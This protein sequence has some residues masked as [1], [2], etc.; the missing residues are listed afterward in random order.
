[1]LTDTGS[2]YRSHTC[3]ELG[4]TPKRTRTHRPRTNGRIERFHL[5]MADGW[6]FAGMFLTG[7]ARRKARP[8]WLHEY[9]HYRPHTAIGT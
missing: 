9:N 7:S 3:A 4:V 5:T 6:A 2:A 1:M 8:A